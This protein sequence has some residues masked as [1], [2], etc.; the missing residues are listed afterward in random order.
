MR[1]C[2]HNNF[3]NLAIFYWNTSAWNNDFN[4]N[5]FINNHTVQCE[6]FISNMSD[7]GCP[8]A[9]PAGDAS[10][11]IVLTERRKERASCYT[12]ARNR[13]QVKPKRLT[14]F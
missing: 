14:L 12:S 1:E 6:A 5:N 10:L 4:D 7:I 3:A 9:L 8:I 11:F 13:R 2:C